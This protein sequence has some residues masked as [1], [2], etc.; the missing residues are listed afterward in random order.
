MDRTVSDQAQLQQCVQSLTEAA[1]APFD[2]WAEDTTEPNQYKDYYY[3]NA[4][5]ARTLWYHDHAIDHT[6]VCLTL[7][8]NIAC[9]RSPFTEKR[10]LWTGRVLYPT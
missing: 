2:G 9:K 1:R 10:I 8:S 5:N 3:P 6:A 7:K 4:Q